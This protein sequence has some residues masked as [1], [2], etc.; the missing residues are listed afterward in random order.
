MTTLLLEKW[1][2]QKKLEWQMHFCIWAT[3]GIFKLSANSGKQN[4]IKI[5]KNRKRYSSSQLPKDDNTS[6]TSF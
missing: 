5:L 2:K 3:V 1:L 6:R 4:N